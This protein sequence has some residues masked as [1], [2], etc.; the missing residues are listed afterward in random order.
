MP[1][2]E[3]LIPPH[4]GTPMNP[5]LSTLEFAIT[6]LGRW[7]WWT[8]EERTYQLEFGMV[9][10]YLPSSKGTFPSNYT[11]ALQFRDTF[12]LALLEYRREESAIPQNWFEL[13]SKD[14]LDPFNLVDY[15]FTLTDPAILKQLYAESSRR[16]FILGDEAAVDSAGDKTAF[17]ALRSG[18]VGIIL[19]AR[20]MKIFS[21]AGEIAEAEIPA[22]QSKWWDYWREYW[23][24]MGTEQALPKDLMCEVNIP[25]KR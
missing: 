17:I 11:L 18:A 9:Q 8:N 2:D 20:E 19:L 23:A 5:N 12:C 13:L 1:D 7:K 15:N 24:K 22:L 21:H 16:E 3:K 4:E 25:V 14:R 6:N 10:L